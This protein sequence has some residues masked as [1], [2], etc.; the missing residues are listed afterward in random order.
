MS[1]SFAERWSRKERELGRSF[2][3]ELVSSGDWTLPRESAPFLSF[4]QAEHPLPVWEAFASPSDWSAEDRQRLAAYRMIGSDGSGNPI[5]VEEGSGA[6]WL[7][8]HE[9]W[10]RTRQF[11]N[12]SVPRLAECLLAYMGEKEPDRFRTAVQ[13]IDPPA[14]AEQTFWWYGASMIESD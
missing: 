11:V 6:V 8:D 5:C 1:E 9:D 10:F 2:V 3:A 4:D 14:L 7:L 12:T 13:Q